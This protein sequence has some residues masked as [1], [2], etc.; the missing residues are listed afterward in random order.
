MSG[1]DRELTLDSRHVA[2]HLPGTPQM[3]RLLQLEGAVHVFN[4]EETMVRVAR[5]IIER[6]KFTGIVR[7]HERYGLYF[8]SP[9][10]YRLDLDGNRIPLHYAEM[11]VSG[12]KYHVIPRTRPS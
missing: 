7:N 1:I 8:A 5:A 10:G 4:D 3:K 9:I 2:K 11:K 12:D 6:G